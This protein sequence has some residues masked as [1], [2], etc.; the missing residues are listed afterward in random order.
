MR[1]ALIA[2]LALILGGAAA[3]EDAKTVPAAVISD[4]APDPDHPARW[5]QLLAPSH[6]KEMNAMLYIASGPEPHPTLVLLH[7]FPGNEQNLDLAQAARRAGWNVLTL[8]YRGSWGSP[9]TFSIA[10]A[11]EDGDAAVALVRRP[12]IAQAYGIDRDRIALAGHSMGGFIGAAHARKDGGLLGV[13]LIDAWNIGGAG[14]ALNE[15]SPTD[16]HSAFERDFNDLGHSLKGATADSVADEI[17][18]HRAAWNYLDWAPALTGLPILVIGAERGFG[19]DNAVL[20]A[21]IA[22]AGGKVTALT[23]ATDH[24]FSDHR[25]ALQAALVGW[26][27]GLA[28]R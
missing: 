3:G 6:G 20:A 5:A 4:P 12:D 10:H 22:A 11:M 18:A 28:A 24:S 21:K 19:Q 8:H 23:M 26:L 25:I 27:Q 16:R 2:T 17:L 1:A 15:M 9:G 13:A 14:L 7:G